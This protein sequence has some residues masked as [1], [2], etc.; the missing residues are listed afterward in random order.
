VNKAFSQNFVGVSSW[1][2]WSIAIRIKSD[3]GGTSPVFSTSE[4]AV[5]FTQS[6]DRIIFG[7]KI[8][9]GN[10]DNAILMGA[11]NPLTVALNR[12]IAWTSQ[13]ATGNAAN[14]NRCL[15]LIPFNSSTLNI[16]DGVNNGTLRDLSLRNLTHTGTI[17][18]ASDERLKKNIRPVSDALAKVLKLAECVKHYEFINQDAYA[19]GQ[20]TGFIAQILQDAGFE[21]HVT[22]RKP[23]NEEEGLLF[24]WSYEDVTVD[25]VDENDNLQYDENGEVKQ[26]TYRV[27]TRGNMILQ[28]EANFDAYIYPAIA[29]MNERLKRIE[30]HLNIV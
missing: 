6:Y 13:N 21:G 11:L 20:R 22:E 3:A 27:S 25:D 10:N 14:A 28:V 8:A 15:G 30:E 16:Y 5:F 4:N 12:G 9:D 24:G 26:I 7:Y 29:E 17:T 1:R 19:A 18:N 23:R 2:V